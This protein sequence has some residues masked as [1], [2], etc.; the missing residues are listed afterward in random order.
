MAVKLYLLGEEQTR[1]SKLLLASQSFVSKWYAIFCKDGTE[2]LK[3]A[4][5]GSQGFLEKREREAVIKWIKQQANLTTKSLQ[6]YIKNE[7]SLE[8]NSLQSY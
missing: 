4:H 2:G 7:Y 8:Y 1:I 6:R 5:K 3:L